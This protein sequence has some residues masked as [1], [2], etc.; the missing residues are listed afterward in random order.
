M[1]VK[2]GIRFDNASLRLDDLLVDMDGG[3]VSGRI[4]LKDWAAP[5]VDFDLAVEDVSAGRYIRAFLDDMESSG[6]KGVC[7]G[8]V[9]EWPVEVTGR[10]EL[11]P[12][13]IEGVDADKLV[14]R[15]TARRDRLE[16]EAGADVI[17]G[18][19]LKASLVSERSGGEGRAEHHVPDRAGESTPG[20][21]LGRFK[22]N[23]TVFGRADA[24]VHFS[25][26]GCGIESLFAAG[27]GSAR[28]R[29]YGKGAD[30]A[31]AGWGNTTLDF[32]LADLHME[33]SPTRNV[34]GAGKKR[35]R[36]ACGHRL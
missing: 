3:S 24:D 16:I 35:C 36:K 29:L 32:S 25:A 14:A 4:W 12:Q 7:A 1:A 20:S 34:A 5:K 15:I 13:R 9:G 28:V 2:T 33:L 31:R 23:G 6:D 27:S 30:S 17:F 21:V 8:Q 18:G 10:L 11:G 26:Q 22:A 19:R